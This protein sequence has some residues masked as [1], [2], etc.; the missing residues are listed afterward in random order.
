[1]S[2]VSF[3]W[4]APSGRLSNVL[5]EVISLKVLKCEVVSMSMQVWRF[6]LRV[7]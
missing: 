4:K 1:V 5:D 6:P 7:N 2:S 3:S